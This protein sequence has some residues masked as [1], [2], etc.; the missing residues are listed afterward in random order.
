MLQLALNDI[1]AVA[2]HILCKK[3]QTDKSTYSNVYHA[4]QLDPG[5]F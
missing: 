1:Q 3:R 4:L 5:Y 2:D